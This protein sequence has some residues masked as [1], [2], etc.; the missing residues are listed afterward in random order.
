M[1]VILQLSAKNEK[2]MMGQFLDFFVNSKPYVEDDVLPNLQMCLQLL[3][4]IK[5]EMCLE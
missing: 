3:F 4:K 5:A 1:K 2:N